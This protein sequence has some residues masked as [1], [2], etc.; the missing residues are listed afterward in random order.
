MGA[1]FTA[2]TLPREDVLAPISEF[3]SPAGDLAALA[4]PVSLL[5]Q[6]GLPATGDPTR[7]EV[8][9]HEQPAWI[10]G[11][12]AGRPARAGERSDHVFEFADARTESTRS[13]AVRDRWIAAV[14][15]RLRELIAMAPGWDGHAG[16]A[17]ELAYISQAI[18]FLARVMGPGTAPPAMVPTSDGGLQLEWHRSGLDVEIL[19]SPEED[20]ILYVHERGTGAEDEVPP[21]EGFAEFD[22][23]KRLAD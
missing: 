19:F 3:I 18:A 16:R 23:G 13:P 1:T 22:L 2:T 20:P 8:V 5:G 11:A 14:T 12:E 4:F 9:V 7:V 17:P 21:V 10:S 15:A 6:W